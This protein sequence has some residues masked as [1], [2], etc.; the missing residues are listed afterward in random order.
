[1]AAHGSSRSRTWWILPY[2]G[3]LLAVIV[4][5]AAVI[6]IR[7]ALQSS[8]HPAATHPAPAPVPMPAEVFPNALF[9]QLTA[10]VAA[11]D[12]SRFLALAAPGARPAMKTWWANL[13]AIGF[14]TGAVIPTASHDTVRID[15]HGNGSTTILAGVHSPLD[16]LQ[17]GKTDVPLDRYRIGLPFASPPATGQITS[18]QP[19]DGGPWDSGAG[20]YV[21]KGT[22][23]I[24]AGPPG[25]SGLVDETLPL[26]QAAASYDLGLLRQVNPNDL[27][28][29]GFVVFVSGSPGVRSGWFATAAQPPGWPL[30]WHGDRAFQLPGPGSSPDDY[31]SAP[32]GLADAS[33]GGARVV[34]TPYEQN[35]QTPQ[36]EILSLV[37][38]FM[39]DILT[40]HDQDLING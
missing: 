17:N 22:D 20:L 32:A 2:F 14:T 33:T 12:E 39:I 5:A 25:D 19:L 27:A 38:E 24:V 11:R 34:V 7:P 35:G 29:E 15:A 10:A 9:G 31:T 16:P 18:W 3:G 36:L 37:R 8:P 1:M 21:R 23:V 13:A 40:A 26:A 6:A 30:A 28:Q 4:V